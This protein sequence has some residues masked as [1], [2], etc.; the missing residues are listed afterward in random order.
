MISE[1]REQTKVQPIKMLGYGGPGRGHL[2]MNPSKT[3]FSA[4]T[5]MRTGSEDPG[6]AYLDLEFSNGTVARG[7]I[8]TGAGLNLM[9]FSIYQRLGL[10]GMKPSTRLLSLADESLK[11][12][13]GEIKDMEVEIEGAR[14]A[15]DF[16]VMMMEGGREQEAEILIGRPFMA[17]TNMIVDMATQG[18]GLTISGEMYHYGDTYEEEE[19]ALW[20]ECCEN[21]GRLKEEYDEWGIKI[22]PEARNPSEWDRWEEKAFENGRAFKKACSE[23]VLESKRK[24]AG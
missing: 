22:E 3:R 18:I 9:P 24:R 8:D 2:A 7:L 5:G 15:M 14:V 11:L 17:A 12:A 23:K 20:I 13:V 21:M 4:Y 1:P 10:D 19:E 16:V 6:V